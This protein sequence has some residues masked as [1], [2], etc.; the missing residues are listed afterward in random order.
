MSARNP[1][2][3]GVTLMLT[4]AFIGL[5]GGLITGVSPCVLPM[6][7]IIFF[8]GTAGKTDTAA[9]KS[10]RIRKSTAASSDGDLLVEEVAVGKPPRDFRPLKIIAG[11][12]VSFSLFTL[13]GSVILSGA[14]SAG[15]LP[16]LGRPHHPDARR[17]RPDL[18]GPGALDREAVLPAPEDQPQ[19]QR[20]V[21]P[22]SRAR[23]A[24]RALRRPGACGNHRRGSDRATSAGAP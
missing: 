1:S 7:P 13:A 11:I 3:V 22:G 21:R 9:P 10:T 4:L 17:P 12:V 18:P 16:A 15:R 8:A 24:V 2:S 23:H 6:L 19:Q 20:R 5:L 14:R